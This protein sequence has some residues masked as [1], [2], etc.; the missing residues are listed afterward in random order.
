MVCAAIGAAL[1]R[2][3]DSFTLAFANQGA[4][5]FGEGTHHRQHQIGHRR[6]L[7]R[8]RQAFLCKF[9][10]DVALRERLDDVAQ[11]IEVPR[12]PVYAVHDHGIAG[13]HEREQRIELRPL[14]VFA[15]CLVGKSAIKLNAVELAL[16]I[17]LERT[18]PHIA[19]ALTVHGEFAAKVSA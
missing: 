14:R 12:E 4:F 11:I 19:D 5:E 9:Y 8:E 16:G 15:R 17:L 3:R 1:S 10:A 6:I 7:T 13:A 18:D 2:E